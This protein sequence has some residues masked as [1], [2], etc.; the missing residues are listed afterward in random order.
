MACTPPVAVNESQGVGPASSPFLPKIL[1]TIDHLQDVELEEA[2]IQ[3]LREISLEWQGAIEK[4]QARRR[5]LASM[6]A[7][8]PKNLVQFDYCKR[9]A[10]ISYFLYCTFS[11]SLTET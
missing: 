1:A 4:T 6:Q 3:E 2:A 10:T 5:E 11:I 9:T 7:E 8:F